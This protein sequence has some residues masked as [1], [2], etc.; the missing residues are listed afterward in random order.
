MPT[1]DITTCGAGNTDSIRCSA[2]FLLQP[3]MS[4]GVSEYGN[5]KPM[6]SNMATRMVIAIF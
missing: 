6:G 4:L 1:Y 2:R 3:D 5:P